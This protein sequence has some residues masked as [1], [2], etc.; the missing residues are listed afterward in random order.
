MSKLI[1]VF[2][3][4]SMSNGHPGLYKMAKSDAE[5][6]YCVF[7]NKQWTALKM[8]TPANVLLHYKTKSVSHRINMETIKY[9]PGCVNGGELDYTK[10]LEAWVGAQYA[11]WEKKK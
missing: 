2:F 1:N 4:V 7:V 10:A 11:R 9:L 3:N 8:I 6:G 5:T